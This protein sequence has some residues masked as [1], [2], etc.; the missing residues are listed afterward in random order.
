M[1]YKPQLDLYEKALENILNKR[2][3]EKIIYSFYL[4]EEIRIG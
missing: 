4:D 3:K 1:K 2:V